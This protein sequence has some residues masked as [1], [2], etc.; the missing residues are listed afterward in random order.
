[1]SN[2]TPIQPSLA[3]KVLLW[4]VTRLAIAATLLIMLAYLIGM[5][6]VES[7]Y[8]DRLLWLL[9]AVG[10][11]L[12]IGMGIERRGLAELGLDGEPAAR[13]T[14]LGALLGALLMAGTVGLHA[15]AGWYAAARGN[16][17]APGF[18]M[19]GMQ[20]F[21]AAMFEEVVFR[22]IF[23]RIVEQ[24]MGSWMA[25]AMSAI[26]FGLAH[27]GNPGSSLFAALAIA[28]E[29]GILLGVAYMLTRNLW[30]VTGIHWAWN[31]AQGPIFGLPV[32]GIRFPGLLYG[33]TNG[34]ELWTGGAFGPEAGLAGMILCLIAAGALLRL[35]LRRGLFIPPPWL[36]KFK[37]QSSKFKV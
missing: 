31:F 18:V 4:P 27:L 3:R 7:E 24:G 14:L 1:M 33:Q 23:F 5:L 35:A 12:L 10:V 29:A 20:L 6:N 21:C 19:L 16:I 9:G 13:D 25:L 8:F 37:V 30:L 36:K 32:S 26:F 2:S 17:G 15:L 22:G 34:P 11:H 28:L